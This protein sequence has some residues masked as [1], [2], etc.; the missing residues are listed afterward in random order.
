MG[1]NAVRQWVEPVELL[2][3][4][5]SAHRAELAPVLMLAPCAA[6]AIATQLSVALD[7]RG[8]KQIE[9]RQMVA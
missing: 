7:L 1:C 9:G 8:L 6:I 2:P 4:E 5:R 3:A